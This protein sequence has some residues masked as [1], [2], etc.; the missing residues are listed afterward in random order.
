VISVTVLLQYADE[1]DF[2]ANISIS[3]PLKAYGAEWLPTESLEDLLGE[4]RSIKEK[5][6]SLAEE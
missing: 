4:S 6:D 2:T 5:V 1:N 3:T